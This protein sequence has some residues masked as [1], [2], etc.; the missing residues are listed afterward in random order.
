MK[1]KKNKRLITLLLPLLLLSGVSAVTGVYA[2]WNANKDTRETVQVGEGC[3]ETVDAKVC[4]WLQAGK[5]IS[6]RWIDKFTHKL[7]KLF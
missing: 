6:P 2:Y 4:L 7:K 1:N 5:G 3:L